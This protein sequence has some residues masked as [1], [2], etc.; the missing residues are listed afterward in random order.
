MT[1]SVEIVN[2]DVTAVGMNISFTV[3]NKTEEKVLRPISG[4][5]GWTTG[6]PKIVPANL[7]RM[8]EVRSE[9]SDRN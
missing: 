6:H 9:E 3:R 7:E 4:E 2:S 1:L 5:K 8:G